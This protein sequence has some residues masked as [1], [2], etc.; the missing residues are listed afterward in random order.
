MFVWVVWYHWQKL[1]KDI[2][3]EQEFICRD[4]ARMM[5]RM[6]MR[7]LLFSEHNVL[8]SLNVIDHTIVNETVV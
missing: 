1:K 8:D 5:M 4:Y 7:I 2:D 3:Y 6:I